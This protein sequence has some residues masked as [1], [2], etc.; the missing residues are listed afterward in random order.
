MEIIAICDELNQLKVITNARM[1]PAMGIITVSDKFCT[2][3]PIRHLA[4][5]SDRSGGY[6]GKSTLP[7][8]RIINLNVLSAGLVLVI[9][10]LMHNDFLYKLPQQSRGKFFKAGMPP[11]NI[12]KLFCVHGGFLCFGK[13]RLIAAALS[14]SSRC[15]AS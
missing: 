15:S 3:V 1:T 2:A 5:V 10:A 12:H 14:F 6:S 11:D 9:A 4:L 13:L 8:K 7:T